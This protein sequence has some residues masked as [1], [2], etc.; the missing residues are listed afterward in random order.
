MR[1]LRVAV[2]MLA[3]PVLI[4][5]CQQRGAPSDQRV[6][7]QRERP[8]VDDNA[9]ADAQKQPLRPIEPPSY[10]VVASMGTCAPVAD[11]V[12]NVSACCNDTPCR[13]QCVIEPGSKDTTC[14]CFGVRGGCPEGEICC[15]RT[16]SC[17]KLEICDWVP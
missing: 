11:G 7:E 8:S 5:G 12:R 3:L 17:A 16:R 1:M 6:N 9:S 10:T 2:V 13:G 14:S 4:A 15:K